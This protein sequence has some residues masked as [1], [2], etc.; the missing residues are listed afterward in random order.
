MIPI[1]E[2][3]AATKALQR[4]IA[5]HA[6]DLSPDVQDRLLDISSEPSPVDRIVHAAEFIYANAS[7]FDDAGMQLCVQLAQFASINSWHGMAVR[8]VEIAHTMMRDLGLE[9][10]TDVQWPEPGAEPAPKDEF[11]IPL[12]EPESEEA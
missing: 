10:P 9:P 5:L 11:V 1:T 3:A 12:D 2:L 8:G 6:A 4:F 7:Q